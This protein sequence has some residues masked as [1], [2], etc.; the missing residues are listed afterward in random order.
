MHYLNVTDSVVTYREKKNTNFPTFNFHIIAMNNYKSKKKK[1]IVCLGLP[2]L[3]GPIAPISIFFYFS[4]Q[5]NVFL[6]EKRIFFILKI[7]NF[8]MDL[9][10]HILSIFSDL[11]TY[12]DFF[13]HVSL[14]KQLFL[15]ALVQ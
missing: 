1:N 4:S 12:L 13:Y 10:F 9:L 2:D 7:A 3:P 5:K 15:L 8:V 11:P 6:E 14:N